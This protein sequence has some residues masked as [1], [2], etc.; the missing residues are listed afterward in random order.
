[1][2]WFEGQFEPGETPTQRSFQNGIGLFRRRGQDTKIHGVTVSTVNFR[3]M[4]RLY[5]P[6]M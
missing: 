4:V 2:E 3:G 1:V 6:G 5:G